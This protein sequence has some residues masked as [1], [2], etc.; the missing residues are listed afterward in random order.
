MHSEK[1][2]AAPGSP[3]A[4]W[5][6]ENPRIAAVEGDELVQVLDTCKLESGVYVMIH[7]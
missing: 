1:A 4:I 7:K 5:N 6:N 2:E 3:F